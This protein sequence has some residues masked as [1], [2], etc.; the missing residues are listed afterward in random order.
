MEILLMMETFPQWSMIEY[1]MFG[2][3]LV[4]VCCCERKLL[5]VGWCWFGVRE[6]YCWL[7]GEAAS[8]TE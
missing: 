4:L 5:L 3:W 2:W 7:A 6:K 1:S 8:R